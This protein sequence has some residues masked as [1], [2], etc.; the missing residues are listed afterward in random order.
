[1]WNTKGWI[2]YVTLATADNFV[3][4]GPQPDCIESAHAWF[5][6]AKAWEARSGLR[7]ASSWQCVPPDS[8]LLR[9]SQVARAPSR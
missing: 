1:M 4:L 9:A 2:L 7:S 6:L 3:S 8:R 5:E